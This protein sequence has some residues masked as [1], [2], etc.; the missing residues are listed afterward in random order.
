MMTAVRHASRRIT[1]LVC[2]AGKGVRV[3]GVPPLLVCGLPPGHQ[4]PHR[5]AVWPVTWNSLPAAIGGDGSG[6]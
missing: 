1:L 4:G 5:D 6:A 3:E 2:A